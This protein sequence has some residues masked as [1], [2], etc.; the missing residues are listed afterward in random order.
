MQTA[1]HL[2][3]HQNTRCMQTRYNGNG[4]RRLGSITQLMLMVAL[5]KMAAKSLV[6]I[7]G[8]D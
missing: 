4:K 5:I 6:N 2:L 7:G 3:V 1:K 8:V